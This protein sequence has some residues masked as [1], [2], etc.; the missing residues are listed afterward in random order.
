MDY[1]IAQILCGDLWL[2]L[3]MTAHFSTILV[4]F[5]SSAAS[6]NLARNWA[7]KLNNLIAI[8]ALSMLCGLA[9][10]ELLGTRSE[11]FQ[12]NTFD[13]LL[14][15]V[16]KQ[17]FLLAKFCDGIFMFQSSCVPEIPDSEGTFALFLGIF[18]KKNLLFGDSEMIIGHTD[19]KPIIFSQ[20]EHGRCFIV[21]TNDQRLLLHSFKSC[22]TLVLK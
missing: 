5:A 22:Q 10:S 21:I 19:E 15:S 11:E 14:F 3:A 8:F 20:W 6:Q 18:C 12:K 13:E 4:K 9:W 2:C 7:K 1:V 16:P 17:C